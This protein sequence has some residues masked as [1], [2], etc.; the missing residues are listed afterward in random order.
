MARAGSREPRINEMDGD[1]EGRKW[2]KA[3]RERRDRSAL[4]RHVPDGLP[5]AVLPRAQYPG[6]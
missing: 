3:S 1:G 2:N 4:V 5:K 6:P